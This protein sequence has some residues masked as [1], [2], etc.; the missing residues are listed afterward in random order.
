MITIMF[1]VQSRVDP[2]VGRRRKGAG[3]EKG[4]SGRE[5]A[6]P[7]RR[8][9]KVRRQLGLWTFLR[10]M[11]LLR[12]WPKLSRLTQLRQSSR[13]TMILKKE[14]HW[15]RKSFPSPTSHQIVIAWHRIKTHLFIGESQKKE[16]RYKQPACCSGGEKTMS[17][18]TSEE[19]LFGN[20]LMNP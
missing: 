17:E 14:Q 3:G 11:Q 5:L 10:R 19:F 9:S 13:I 8:K 15:C 16:E 4:G 2:G 20:I 1:R 12:P 18:E 6:P 7:R